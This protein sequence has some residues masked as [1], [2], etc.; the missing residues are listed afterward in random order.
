MKNEI[1]SK[2]F[3]SNV[4]TVRFIQFLTSVLFKM[5]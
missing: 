3:Q 5:E 1:F 2:L 4:P